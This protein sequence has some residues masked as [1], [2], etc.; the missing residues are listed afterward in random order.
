MAHQYMVKI[1]YG[2]HKNPPPPSPPSYILNVPSLNL[3]YLE[4]THRDKKFCVQKL[5]CN[6]NTK[7]ILGR[8]LENE[9]L[10]G[11][12]LTKKIKINNEML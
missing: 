12:A 10:L 11:L 4:I 5:V 9:K 8:P 7:A 6:V 2:P 1:F 3:K